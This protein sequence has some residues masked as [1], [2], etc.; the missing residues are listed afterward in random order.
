MFND[1][2][3]SGGQVEFDPLGI[4]D[5]DLVGL[6]MDLT[7]NRF[8]DETGSANAADVDATIH[9]VLHV[10]TLDAEWEHNYAVLKVLYDNVLLTLVLG[11][12]SHDILVIVDVFDQKVVSRIDS[13]CC[14][15]R[16]R[17]LSCG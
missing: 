17:L 12:S 13:I 8:V 6:K 4:V 14:S 15:L 10:N 9:Q 1:R 16:S 3:S 7:V 5:S 11:S 2:A